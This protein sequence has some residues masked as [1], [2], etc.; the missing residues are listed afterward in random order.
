MGYLKVLVVH[1]QEAM[2]DE[3]K[4]ILGK[5]EP[6][7]RL[8]YCGIDGLQ[9]AS[10]ENFDL[11]LCSIDLPLITGFEMAR[12]VRNFSKNKNTATVL[13]AK[14]IEVGYEELCKKLNVQILVEDDFLV[15]LPFII[16]DI[17]DSIHD[18]TIEQ[19]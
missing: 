19:A 8:C 4:T 5:S 10:V 18:E 3:I 14:Q 2:L 16:D 11:I 17:C 6:Y 15:G 12:A 9:A 13:I 7:L 1:R